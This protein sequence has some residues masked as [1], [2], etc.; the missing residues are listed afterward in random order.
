MNVFDGICL[1]KTTTIEICAIRFKYLLSFIFLLIHKM[2]NHKNTKK[3]RRR[4]VFMFTLSTFSRWKQNWSRKVHS[5]LSILS[6]WPRNARDVHWIYQT[7]TTGGCA[8]VTI[9]N[10]RSFRIGNEKQVENDTTINNYLLIIYI[11]KK[12]ADTKWP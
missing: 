5:N 9:A 12:V 4:R 11:S 8:M 10:T 7:E 3:R 1:R 6:P 2:P